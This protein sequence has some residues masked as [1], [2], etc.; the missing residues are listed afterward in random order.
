MGKQV[1]MAVAML[2]V[3]VASSATAQTRGAEPIE[4]E[5]HVH[6]GR[7][8]VP[9]EVE[10]GTSMEFLLGTG[11]PTGWTESTATRLGDHAQ[12]TL[13]G[14]TIPTDDLATYPDSMLT[15]DGTTL[16]GVVGPNTL[17]RFDVLIDVPGARLVLK[18]IGRSVEWEGMTLSNPV[19]LRIMHGVEVWLSV[20]L[21]GREYQAILDLGTPRV[22]ANKRVQT[23]T[24]LDD[25]DLTTLRL[26]DTTL[27]DVPVFI[28]ELDL[29]GFTV[30][31]RGFVIVGAPIAYNCAVSL[32]WAHREMR[33]CVR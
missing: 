20:E 31:G 19:D 15:I 3:A 22:V 21:A 23:E 32:S 11:W 2:T 6:R 27:S 5:L 29:G 33:M 12:L 17:S 30:G 10:D 4:A 16:A 7:L 24:G 14:L 25:D 18:P 9:V 1:T 28:R 26:G 8:F 13:G